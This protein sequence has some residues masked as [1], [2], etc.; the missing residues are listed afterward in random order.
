MPSWQYFAAPLMAG[1]ASVLFGSAVAEQDSTTLIS[2]PGIC[3]ANSVRPLTYRVDRLQ[4]CSFLPSTAAGTRNF[5]GYVSGLSSRRSCDTRKHDTAKCSWCFTG[6][7]KLRPRHI[8][9]GIARRSS[10]QHVRWWP[11]GVSSLHGS[12]SRC[13][14]PCS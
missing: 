12:R 14:W 4:K 6:R 2:F 9:L 1:S 10:G 11:S 13:C 3:R 5:P 7:L 8:S